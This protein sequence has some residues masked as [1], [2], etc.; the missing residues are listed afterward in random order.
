MPKRRLPPLQF[1]Q[2]FEAAGRLLSFKK[3]ADELH[4]TPSAI[5]QQIKSL[6]ESLGIKLFERFVRGLRLTE[7]GQVYWQ[8]ISDTLTQLRLSSAQLSER[9]GHS[10]LRVNIIPFIANEVVIPALHT[11]QE[12]YPDIELRI[13]T[14]PNTLDLDIEEIDMAVLVGNGKWPGFT[15]E[16]LR[17]IVATPVCSPALA[18]QFNWKSLQDL[19]GQTF[20]KVSNNPDHWQFLAEAAGLKEPVPGNELV[21]DNYYAAMSA[22]QRNLGI[23]LGFFPLTTSWVA[24]GRLVAPLGDRATV[25]DAHYVLCRNTSY[26]RQ[27]C[28][29]FSQWMKKRFARLIPLENLDPVK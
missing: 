25:P 9:F 6:E 18:N 4:V 3:A 1:L 7:A 24:A 22:A 17:D 19:S 29:A 2:A 20:I 15:S 11:F 21:F 16:K 23:A 27:E 28:Q 8:N 26:K 13:E 12:Q 14:S 5:S 10:V